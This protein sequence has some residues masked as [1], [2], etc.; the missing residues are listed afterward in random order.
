[1][2]TFD[3]YQSAK[4]VQQVRDNIYDPVARIVVLGI[5]GAGN[6]AINHMIDDGV[7]GVE[8][9]GVNTDIQDLRHCRAS[10]RVTIGEKITGGRGCGAIPEIGESAANESKE[11]IRAI[12]RE[13]ET[14]KKADMVFIT[15]GMGGGT[16]TGAAPIVAS[17]AKE[18]GILTV[19]V[20][21]KP[22]RFEGKVR[23]QRALSGINK[24]YPNVDTLISIANDKLLNIVDVKDGFREAFAKAD[25]ILKQSIRGITDLINLPALVNLDFADVA[26]VMRGKGLAHI[27]IGE[28]QGENRVSDAIK[29]AMESPLLDTTI[30]GA[31]DIIVSICGEVSLVDVDAAMREMEPKISTDANIIFGA[32]EDASL[33][34]VATVTLIATGI[35]DTINTYSTYSKPTNYQ[36]MYQNPSYYQNH[37]EPQNYYA[38]PVNKT[39]E[40]D[41]FIKA[42]LGSDFLAPKK[43]EVEEVKE[44]VGPSGTS[45]SLDSLNVDLRNIGFAKKQGESKGLLPSFITDNFKK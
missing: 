11:A 43:K 2:S 40:R 15:C 6:N 20:V 45:K 16:G 5:G 37:R 42:T 1:M 22:F 4:P 23:M 38:E 41:S 24:L 35:K 44:S 13:T 30:D 19:A 3:N 21:T 33:K 28:G 25:E 31:T 18:E 26:T 27:S 10:K 7:K 17:I 39:E 34:D 9:V 29:K 8:F 14:Q 12:L 32:R 36:N